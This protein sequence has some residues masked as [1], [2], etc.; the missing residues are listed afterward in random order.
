MFAGDM[1]ERKGWDD[2]VATM[3]NRVRY[4]NQENDIFVF[5]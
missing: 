5:T 2:D 4:D 1:T 3:G